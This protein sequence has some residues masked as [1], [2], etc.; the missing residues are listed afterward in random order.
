MVKMWQLRLLGL[1]IKE[2][3]VLLVLPD[4]PVPPGLMVAMGLMVALDQLVQPVLPDL[5]V[6]QGPLPVSVLHLPPQAPLE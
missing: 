3:L 6:P 4:H 2:I 1:V 5:L